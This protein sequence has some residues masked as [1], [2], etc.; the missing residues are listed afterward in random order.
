M[1]NLVYAECSVTFEMLEDK[2]VAIISDTG[3]FIVTTLENSKKYVEEFYPV[4]AEGMKAY[5]I[6]M[7]K[8]RLLAD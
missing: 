7:D 4:N 1:T 5:N 8:G 6:R 3:I 2:M